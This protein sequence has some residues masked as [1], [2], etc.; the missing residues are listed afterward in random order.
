MLCNDKCICLIIDIKNVVFYFI[1]VRDK[2][3]YII[4]FKKNLF[5]M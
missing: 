5:D 1:L 4:E 2:F 3:V